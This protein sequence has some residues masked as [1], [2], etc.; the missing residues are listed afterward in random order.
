MVAGNWPETEPVVEDCERE[1]DAVGLVDDEDLG[2]RREGT[3]RS[4]NL[5]V[6]VLIGMEKTSASGLKLGGV[7]A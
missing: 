7:M 5:D 1:D 4:R 6:A 3:G 2:A